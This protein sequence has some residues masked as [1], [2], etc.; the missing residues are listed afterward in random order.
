MFR[1]IRVCL[2][3]LGLGVVGVC[4][5]A[6]G[7]PMFTEVAAEAGIDSVYTLSNGLVFAPG[8]L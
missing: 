3:V 6:W 1:G 7:Q 8:V 5:G 2:L 4:S